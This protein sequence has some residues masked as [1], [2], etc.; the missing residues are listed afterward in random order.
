[1]ISPHTPSSSLASPG[2]SGVL[3]NVWGETF[4]NGAGVLFD[5]LVIEASTDYRV[6][7]RLRLGA[8]PMLN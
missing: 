5:C 6:V 4:N 8:G 2:S 1:M 7:A 3:S